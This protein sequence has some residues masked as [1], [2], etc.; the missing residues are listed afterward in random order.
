[1]I[2]F[3]IK[4]FS[5]I[6][7]DNIFLKKIKYYA[8]LRFIV[9]FSA[10]LLL[11][12]YFKISNIFTKRKVN[13]GNNSR[14]IIVSLT[15]FPARIGKV[16]LVVECMLRQTY[17]PDRIILW[18]SKN[19][20]D[21]LQSLPKSLLKLQKR[22]L[23]IK[24]CEGDI[25]SH[26]KYF[27]SLKNFPEAIIITVDDDFFYPTN[28]IKELVKSHQ[29]YPD[30]ISCCRAL[31]Y[32]FTK[33]GKLDK[34]LSWE[35]VTK[36]TDPS[37]KIFYTTGGGTLF[38]SSMFSEEVLNKK[39]FMNHCKYADDIW[40][41]F[42]SLKVNT[43]VV[44]TTYIFE[45]IPILIFRDITLSSKNVNDGLNDKQWKDLEDFYFN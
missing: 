29:K 2:N 41:N 33:N 3:H 35:Y 6:I 32:R 36:A 17:K 26:K 15:T 7:D 21:G 34:Y 42:M 40:L 23:E 11:P 44:K 43:K 38:K 18:L 19:Q 16:W 13:N 4:L 14:E 27:Y 1:M 20:F 12:L 8:F 37:L 30:A 10:N 28:L 5:S 25:R 39:V 31:K 9:K 22:G 24:F 45:P